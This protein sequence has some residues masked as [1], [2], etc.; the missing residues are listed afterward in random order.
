VQK[1]SKNT[2]EKKNQDLRHMAFFFKNSNYNSILKIKIS[3]TIDNLKLMDMKF[4]LQKS[5]IKL[6]EV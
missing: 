5:S 6:T 2:I 4:F 1:E 3:V